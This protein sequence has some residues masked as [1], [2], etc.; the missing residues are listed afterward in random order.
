MQKRDKIKMIVAL[1]LVLIM[2]IT[3]YFFGKNSLPMKTTAGFSL[4]FWIATMIYVNKKI[5]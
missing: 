3:Y 1:S 4:V 2:V 5:K